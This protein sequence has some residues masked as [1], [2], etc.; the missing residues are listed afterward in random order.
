M[1]AS[2]IPAS[3]DDLQA[4]QAESSETDILAPLRAAEEADVEARATQVAEAVRQIAES[5]DPVGEVT[6]EDYVR[7]RKLLKAGQYKAIVD[8]ARAARAA[9]EAASA[10][11][12]TAA[13]T[14]EVAAAFAALG[15]EL[16]LAELL[17]LVLKTLKRFIVFPSQHAAVAVTLFAAL[18]HV[19]PELQFAPRLD[20]RSPIKR[21]GKSRLFDLLVLLVHKALVTVNISAAAVVHAIDEGDPPTI[22]L[23]EADR[24][25]SAA[26]GDE[27]AEALIGILNGGYERGRPYIRHD[28]ATRSN[29]ECPTFAMAVIAGIGKRPDTIED[30][31]VI[32]MLQRKAPGDSVEKYRTRRHK[33]YVIALGKQLQKLVAPHAKEI[34]AAE[35]G[36]PFGLN[37]RAEDTWEG[38][39]AVADVAGGDW[40]ALARAA[41]RNLSGEAEEDAAE[42][43]R[44]LS[45]LAA[46][47]TVWKPGKGDEFVADGMH[48]KLHTATI[49]EALCKIPEAPW[50]EFGKA[51]R[52]RT[53]AWRNCSAN[54]R[55]GPATSRSTAST[56][57]ATAARICTTRGAAT[58]RKSSCPHFGR[59][60]RSRGTTSS[61]RLTKTLPIPPA[62]PALPALPR[63]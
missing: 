13:D 35:P 37:D 48:D 36:M 34:G 31:S 50:I 8:T 2:E 44:L 19:Q 18:A 55:S 33:P 4:D 25:F 57:R 61:P 20:I 26:K 46:V 6:L 28:P 10:Q 7:R 16:T 3:L 32:I 24:T 5:V 59:R 29:R 43:Q 23:D 15:G 11:R 62:L 38:L 22:M 14:S 12:D 9:R 39:L 56:R 52:S 47:F 54:T 60:P 30:R 40:P 51:S 41:A 1:T 53:V 17:D 27:K 63:R 42:S 49:L 58:L 21:C 45:D